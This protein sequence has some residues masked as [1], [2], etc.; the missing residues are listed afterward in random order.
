MHDFYVV[1]F[2]END[3]LHDCNAGVTTILTSDGSETER[4]IFVTTHCPTSDLVGT[5]N[6]HLFYIS[7]GSLTVDIMQQWF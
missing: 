4:I 7:V 1:Q 5:M 3:L 6:N 2:R